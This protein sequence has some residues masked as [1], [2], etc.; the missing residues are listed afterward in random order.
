MLSYHIRERPLFLAIAIGSDSV[1]QH[2]LVRCWNTDHLVMAYAEDRSAPIHRREGSTL[3]KTLS[4]PAARSPPLGPSCH[5]A[6][7]AG[8]S[9]SNSSSSSSSSYRVVLQQAVVYSN[10]SSEQHQQQ[11]WCV[12]TS[13]C[14]CCVI[15]YSHVLAAAA[16]VHVANLM[17]LLARRLSLLLVLRS[18]LAF[19]AVVAMFR[20]AAFSAAAYLTRYLLVLLRRLCFLCGGNSRTFV[21]VDGRAIAIVIVSQASTS[22]SLLLAFFSRQNLS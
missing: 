8:S 10:N 12:P 3:R 13:W 15:T 6:A 1:S 22:P 4:F 16:A 5:L 2:E 21:S 9:S 14:L 11:R 20:C 19:A 17:F 7:H 18:A